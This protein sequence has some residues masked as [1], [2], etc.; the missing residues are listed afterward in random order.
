MLLNT[1]FYSINILPTISNTKISF[2]YHQSHNTALTSYKTSLSFSEKEFQSLPVY[3]GSNNCNYN[4]KAF[5]F[6]SFLVCGCKVLG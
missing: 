4:N 2:S 1:S 3:V 5:I 6:N